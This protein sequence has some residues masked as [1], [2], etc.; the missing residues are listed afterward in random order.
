MLSSHLSAEDA[1]ELLNNKLHG[2][3]PPGGF[4]SPSG[5]FA[6]LSFDQAVPKNSQHHLADWN[7]ICILQIV[8]GF[9]VYYLNSLKFS[10]IKDRQIIYPALTFFS[11]FSV[12]K[13]N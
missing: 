11:Y 4:V 10:D 13:Q 8:P 12:N 3:S 2:L 5:R 6:S 9:V 1:I 7:A